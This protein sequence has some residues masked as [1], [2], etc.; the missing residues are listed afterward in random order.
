MFRPE[1]GWTRWKRRNEFCIYLNP[2]RLGF[3]RALR[4]QKREISFLSL[5]GINRKHRSITQG[6]IFPFAGKETLPLINWINPTLKRS[7][8]NTAKIDLE[9]I[10]KK[11]QF[12]IYKVNNLHLREL[13]IPFQKDKIKEN[14]YH[15]E[16]LKLENRG[17]TRFRS[18]RMPPSHF[19]RR[20]RFSSLTG[21]T[22]I[23]QGI[24]L[25]CSGSVNF[26]DTRRGAIVLLR[27]PVALRGNRSFRLQLRVSCAI[28][29]A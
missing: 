4:Q 12:K 14:I 1:T 26:V 20:P 16:F 6:F 25:T 15:F 2:T 23:R 24:E 9:L 21:C 5:R 17:L 11:E 3:S 10:K 19:P 28:R 7:D 18:M 29:L 22:F 8:Q 13:T 27:I